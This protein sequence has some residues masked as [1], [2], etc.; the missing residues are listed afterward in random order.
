MS[1]RVFSVSESVCRSETLRDRRII[2]LGTLEGCTRLACGVTNE[3]PPRPGTFFWFLRW[4]DHEATVFVVVIHASGLHAGASVCKVPHTIMIIC[5][6]VQ[7]TPPI[8]VTNGG[9]ENLVPCQ[10]GFCR[11][12]SSLP[13]GRHPVVG[14]AYTLSFSPAPQELL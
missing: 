13:F 14:V 7:L 11:G 4:F 9:H 12:G 1:P 6:G 5:L 3:L 8:A 10:D 2:Q